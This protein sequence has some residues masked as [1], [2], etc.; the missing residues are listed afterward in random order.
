MH[1]TPLAGAGESAECTAAW[2]LLEQ[3][4]GSICLLTPIQGPHI[5][6]HCST[7]AAP[8]VQKH[9]QESITLSRQE[10]QKDLQH[11]AMLQQAFVS[12]GLIQL[13]CCLGVCN[14][15]AAEGSNIARKAC[16]S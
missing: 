12:Q 3:S 11:S 15:A 10:P 1:T 9:C 2:H 8:T 6:M 14:Y 7:V 4:A 16:W 13:V 5:P